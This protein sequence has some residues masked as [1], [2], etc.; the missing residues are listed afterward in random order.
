MWVTWL[1]FLATCFQLTHLWLLQVFGRQN[2]QMENHSVCVCVYDTERERET[3]LFNKL[4]KNKI[5][6]NVYIKNF[7]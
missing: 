4:K 3:L 7:A 5:A 6:I 2:Q 1:E